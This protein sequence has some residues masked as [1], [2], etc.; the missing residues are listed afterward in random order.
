MQPG[1]IIQAVDRDLVQNACDVTAAIEKRGCVEM[2]L[3]VRRSGDTFGIR[4]RPVEAAKLRPPKLDDQR[5]CE[6][7]D[8][9][10]CTALAKAHGED[11]VLMRQACDL[12]DPEGCYVAGL[13]VRD[14]AEKVAFYQQ[15][16]DG[17][18]AQACTNLGWM[19]QNAHG[20]NKDP[21]AAARLYKRACDGNACYLPNNLGCVNLGRMFRDGEGVEQNQTVAARL[22]RDVCARS[23][24]SDEDAKNIARSCSLAGTAYL[25]GMGVPK[26][27]KLALPLLEKGCAANDTFGCFN[28]GTVYEFATGVA[29]D[30]A[31]AIGYYQNA[32]DH[33]DGEACDRAAALRN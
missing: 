4:L 31:R 22:F 9:E 26:D 17:G 14:D 27:I 3:T 21:A 15:A 12:G 10:A 32:C 33:G 23:P 18:Y 28:L 2:K 19:Y 5:A 8:G 1:D 11:V 24:L 13:K 7:G 29:A 30:K 16:C 20:V 6:Q 25:E